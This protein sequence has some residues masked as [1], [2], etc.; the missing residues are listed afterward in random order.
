MAD[1][2]QQYFQDKNI[3][4]EFTGRHSAKPATPEQNA[5][6]ESYHSIMESVVCKRYEFDDLK[7]AILTMNQFR[8]FYN[9]KRI[10]SGVKYKSPY[11]FLLNRGID[12]KKLKL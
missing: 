10:H 3:I 12:M 2:V 8:E 7:D 11:R 6:I 9:F 1:L 4:Q 5:H